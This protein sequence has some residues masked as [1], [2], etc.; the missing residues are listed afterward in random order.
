MV[1]LNIQ[2]GVSDDFDYE[3][4]APITKTRLME[5]EV[6]EVVQTGV[7]PNPTKIPALAATIK[8]LDL[9]LWRNRVNKDNTAL[10]IMQSS[11]PDSV[12]R[13]TISVAS[14]KELWDLLYKGNGTEEAKIRRLEKQLENLEMDEE[15]HMDLYLK[16]VAKLIDG[17]YG[18][19]KQ[20]DDEKLVAKLIASLPERYEDCIPLLEE[21]MTLPDLTSR[22]LLTVLGRY[23]DDP[24]T[25]PE[26]LKK[27]IDFLRKAWADEEMWC[28]VCERDNHNEED[29]YYKPK[30]VNSRNLQGAA[31]TQQQAQMNQ[32]KIQ[33]PEHLMLAVPVTGLRYDMN[34]WLVHPAT[35][36]HMTPY[37]KFFTTLDRSY[38][39]RVGLVDGRV[40]MVHGKGD[41]MFM[42]KGGKKRIRNVLFVPGI[43]K[44]VLSVSQM[45]ADEGGSVMMDGEKC[46]IKNEGGKV[47]GED[48]VD[49]RRGYVMRLQVIKEGIRH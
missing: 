10:K 3:Q 48:W 39:A 18:L 45:T 21:F 5:D 2:D 9:A 38:R 31:A 42:T 40:I 41:V 49:E 14:S 19:G 25:M 43:D 11:L 13:K 24:R 28:D 37:E 7:S 36:N 15:E 35:T 26:E 17:F 1:A 29:C 34:L 32:K 20:P 12:F 22:D 47:F 23:G 44:N 6:W 16:R 33:K 4:W 46:I 27:F 8:P 30:V